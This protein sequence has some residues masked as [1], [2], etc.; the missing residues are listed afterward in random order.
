M[1][2][3]EELDVEQAVVHSDLAVCTYRV[4]EHGQ[5]FVECPDED[6]TERAHQAAREKPELIFRVNPKLDPSLV[7]DGEVRDG[8]A[9]PKRR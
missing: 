2:K 7:K 1:V 5:A 8:E 6:S 4:D 3:R 9:A